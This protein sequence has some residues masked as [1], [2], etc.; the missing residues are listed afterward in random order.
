MD[1]VGQVIQVLFD[2]ALELLADT[3]ATVDGL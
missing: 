3:L 2:V 1:V